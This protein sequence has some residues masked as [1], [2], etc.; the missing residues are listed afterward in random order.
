MSQCDINIHYYLLQLRERRE[1][2][3]GL[4]DQVVDCYHNG[5]AKAIHN[6]S[7]ILNLFT[8]S[9]V[10]VRNSD[11]VCAI[12]CTICWLQTKGHGRISPVKGTQ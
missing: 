2:I 6:Y 8:D 7:Q 12:G 5:F 10:Q 4:V 11:R 1:I 9:K 3:E